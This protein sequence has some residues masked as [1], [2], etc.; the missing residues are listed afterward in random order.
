MY[1]AIVFF[2]FDGEMRYFYEKELLKNYMAPKS[3]MQRI[4]NHILDTQK[5][6]YDSRTS[7]ANK[8]PNKANN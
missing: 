2:K 3:A 5:Y 6:K 8:P 1:P 4:L 7:T